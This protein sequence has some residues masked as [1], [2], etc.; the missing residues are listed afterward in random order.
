MLSPWTDAPVVR[1]RGCGGRPKSPSS[2]GPVDQNQTEPHSVIHG[3]E[4][5]TPRTRR[6]QARADPPR[7]TGPFRHHRSRQLPHP[8]R[9]RSSGPSMRP[10]PWARPSGV[11]PERESRA[12]RCP[13]LT[14]AV[15]PVWGG[16][17]SPNSSSRRGTCSSG[18]QITENSPEGGRFLARFCGKGWLQPT[19]RHTNH[20]GRDQGDH[21]MPRS[22]NGRATGCCRRRTNADGNRQGG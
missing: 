13:S 17:W 3:R 1:T 9:P 11:V 15:A 10:G 5:R 7:R 19:L 20:A 6:T 14:R 2:V 18:T 12:R 16:F 8:H 4:R 22:K 21:R